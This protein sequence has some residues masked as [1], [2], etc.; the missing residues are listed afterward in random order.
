M[1]YTMQI[2]REAMVSTMVD[3]E[4]D[5][6]EEVESEA[7]KAALDTSAADWYVLD[8]EF[9]KDR[10]DIYKMEEMDT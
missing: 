2:T 3:I 5:S 8:H 6:E 1:K 4:V 10:L 9:Y 7:R